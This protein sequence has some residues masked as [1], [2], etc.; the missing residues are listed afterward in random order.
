MTFSSKITNVIT[1]TTD[2]RTSYGSK[3]ILQK[4][5]K[6]LIEEIGIEAVR[7]SSR[8]LANHLYD[9]KRC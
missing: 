8:I 6:K 7:G 5:L 4:L 2:L 3:N 9:P 1:N